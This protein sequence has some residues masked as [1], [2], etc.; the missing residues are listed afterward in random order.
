MLLRSGVHIDASVI[1]NQEDHSKY[2]GV[3]LVAL[4]YLV[5]G[6]YV[7]SG[8]GPRPAPLTFTFS[9]WRRL[10]S[11]PFKYTDRF[12]DFDW[13]IYWGNVAATALQ[14]ALFLHFALAFPLESPA[15][16]AA[17]SAFAAG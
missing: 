4:V 2:N 8:A 14:P 6:L 9:A 13:V 10:S 11:T 5:I 1:L 7:L 3:R 12:T 17:S 16:T 15:T